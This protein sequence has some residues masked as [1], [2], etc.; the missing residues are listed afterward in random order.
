MPNFHVRVAEFGRTVEEIRLRRQA[1][2]RNQLKGS[3]RLR[4][5]HDEP[6]SKTYRVKTFSQQDLSART[7]PPYMAMLA[8]RD[9]RHPPR[10]IVM[11]MA[12]Y[13]NCTLAERNRILVAAG[14]AP[15]EPYLQGQLLDDALGYAHRVIHYLPLPSFVV[16]RDWQVHDWNATLLTLYDVSDAEVRAIP[17]KQR[18]VLHLLFDETLPF[19][20]RLSG[21]RE[22]WLYTAIL[23]IYGF[24][25][26]NLL[27]RYDSWYIELVERLRDQDDFSELW[28]K[29]EIDSTLPLDPHNT[30]TF[31]LYSTEI[32]THGTS[33][34]VMGI[35]AGLGNFDY[36]MVVSYLPYD[37]KAQAKFT[38]LGL[39]TPDNQWKHTT[40]IS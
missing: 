21:H 28:E 40:P 15:E 3:G 36:P 23:N 39:P 16:T 30:S 25:H 5:R 10:F 11:N 38:E 7:Y 31:P 8:G 18:N 27:C 2:R 12:E 32:L 17:E 34:W 37:D 24:K 35:H 20:S 14:Y 4:R 29:V 33:V 26:Q 22:T 6:V 13:L 9:N 19:R 1:E